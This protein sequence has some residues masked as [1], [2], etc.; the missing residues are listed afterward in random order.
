MI[1]CPSCKEEIEEDS[2]FCDQC[3]Q[4]L[5][6]CRSCGRVGK[7]RRCIYCGGLMMDIEELKNQ[8]DSLQSMS[9]FSQRGGFVTGSTTARGFITDSQRGLSM[10][11]SM[12]MLTLYNANLDI[13]IV[14]QNGAVIGRR[15]GPYSH[16]F[17]KNMYVSGV[18]AQLVYNSDTGWSIIDK[19]SSNGTKLNDRDLQ[20][21][22]PMSLKSGDIVT[23]ANVSM[24]VTV[25]KMSH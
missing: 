20:P 14:G 5:V 3:G 8:K 6:Y 23:I 24:Q 22:V 1:I 13:R 18:H 16:F 12:P 7:G 11:Q 15:Q 4:A 10:T 21:D 9:S 2:H 17:E 25:E 19:H